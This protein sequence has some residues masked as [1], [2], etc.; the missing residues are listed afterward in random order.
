MPLVQAQLPQSEYDLLRRRAQAEGKPLKSVIREALRAHLLPDT[1][2]P[3]DP[4][5]RIFP[6][7]KR[8][9]RVHWV[10]RDHDEL[11]YPAQR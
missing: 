7:Q 10:S 3:T 4:I 2:E 8:R 11:L 1:I 9:G 5:F 6:L